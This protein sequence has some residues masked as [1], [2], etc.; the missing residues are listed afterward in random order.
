[1]CRVPF[2]SG[3][4]DANPIFECALAIW[5]KALGPEHFHTADSTQ[6]FGE[7]TF[8][9]QE[10]D[11]VKYVC[12]GIVTLLKIGR[13]FVGILYGSNPSRGGTLAIGTIRDP[14]EGGL[15]SDERPMALTIRHAGL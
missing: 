11:G 6:E 3:C 5:E 10:I 4:S 12:M 9:W 7:L 14:F 15:N 1:V 13:G 8:A 2:H